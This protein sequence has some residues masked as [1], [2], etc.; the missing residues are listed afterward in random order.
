[1]AEGAFHLGAASAVSSWQGGVDEM[2]NAFVQ[3]GMAGGVFRGIGN[4]IG[5]GNTAGGKVAKTLAGSLF[6]GLPSTVQGATTPEQVY[7][8]VMGAWFGGQERPW[9]VARAGKEV[10][11]FIKAT[12]EHPELK[13]AMDPTEHP[14]FAKL[15][16]EVKPVLVEMMK[17]RFG[18]PEE[19]RKAIWDFAQKLGV[20]VDKAARVAENLGEYYEVAGP[21]GKKVKLKPG[22]L[23]GFENFVITSGQKGLESFIAR[24]GNKRNDRIANIHMV[25]PE[26]RKSIKKKFTPGVAHKLSPNELSEANTAVQRA[27][28]VLGKALSDKAFNQVSKN[29]FVVKNADALYVSGEFRKFRDKDGKVRN[30][31]KTQLEGAPGW[32]AQMAIDM[33]KPVFV[34]EHNQNKWFKYL[35]SAKGFSAKEPSKPPR[36]MGFISDATNKKESQKAFATLFEK[37]FP[38]KIEKKD[39]EAT[40]ELDKNDKDADISDVDAAGSLPTD[41]PEIGIN[42][43]RFVKNYMKNSA[44]YE[45]LIG[46]I[47]ESKMIEDMDKISAIFPKYHNP[48]SKVN[49]SE[50]FYKELKNEFNLKLDAEQEADAQGFLRQWVSRRNNDRKLIQFTSDGEKIYKMNDDLQKSKAGNIKRT[51][52]P[53]KI[54]DEIWTALTGKDERAFAFLDHITVDK[55]GFTD[56]DISRFRSSKEFGEQKFNDL[57]S[58]GM[59]HW[60]KKEN[61][62]FYYF[63]GKAD[64]DRLIFTKYHPETDKH[65]FMEMTR[66]FKRYKI[67]QL[68]DDFASKFGNFKVGDNFLTKKQSEE[69]FDKAFVSNILWNLSKNGLEF[70]QANIKKML[71]PGFIKDVKGWN[72]RSQVWMT[73]SYSADKEFYVNK[74]KDLTTEGNF[75]FQIDNE[76]DTH[77]G[78]KL[79]DQVLANL[80]N[81]EM[82]EHMDGAIIVRDDVIDVMNLDAGHPVSGQNKSFIIAPHAEHGALLGKYMFHAAGKQQ[83]ADMLASGQHMIIQESAAKQMGTRQFDTTYELDPSSI[84]FNYSVRQGPEMLK[85][86]SLKKQLLNSLVENLAFA[87]ETKNGVNMSEVVNDI[88]EST[89]EPRYRGTKKANTAIG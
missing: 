50:E 33:N 85:R 6:M 25:T 58:R 21:E 5:T 26:E 32:A 76:M 42:P 38:R 34:F 56:M 48:K 8:Y 75:R 60:A 86:Q 7:Q 59:K 22:A 37:H 11:K 36:A 69:Y 55:K 63:G 68:R 62:G 47:K 73:D 20:D 53:K 15:P 9:T 23:A 10:E 84:K 44:A 80:K 74:V 13:V 40:K 45:G 87:P 54:I 29:Y 77:I 16:T 70:S 1:M 43:F 30:V 24:E 51:V 4:Y 79:K 14:D 52:E 12:K 78:A 31:S 71:G 83:T 2:M 3:G 64:N 88:F 81:T 35:P 19:N 82:T 39:I 17:A 49:R 67:K 66:N 61:G 57:M 41:K 46:P 27:S 28:N 65:T 72:K 89:I 18:A